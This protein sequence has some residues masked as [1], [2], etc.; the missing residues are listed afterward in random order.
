[1][2]KRKQ[3]GDVSTDTYEPKQ[4]KRRRDLMNDIQDIILK[5]QET[6]RQNA[7]LKRQL[8]CILDLVGNEDHMETSM[9]KPMTSNNDEPIV[10]FD[11]RFIH[12]IERIFEVKRENILLTSRVKRFMDLLD[13]KEG[14][15][16]INENKNNQSQPTGRSHSAPK[17]T[18]NHTASPQ[19]ESP[20][21]DRHV[22]DDRYPSR[23]LS[24]PIIKPARH[25]PIDQES[26]SC[27]QDTTSLFQM[28]KQSSVD[29]LVI[30]SEGVGWRFGVPIYNN[31]YF[32]CA[33]FNDIDADEFANLVV[34]L[35]CRTDLEI[36]RPLRPRPGRAARRTVKRYN[37][38]ECA[39]L[40]AVYDPVYRGL[41]RECFTLGDDA[42]DID[43][44]KYVSD[45]K[46][47]KRG[48]RKYVIYEPCHR[49]KEVMK[50][51]L[52]LLLKIYLKYVTT[53]CVGKYFTPPWDLFAWDGD[54]I[55]LKPVASKFNCVDLTG[56]EGDKEYQE[57]ANDRV[58]SGNVIVKMEAKCMH[59]VNY[60]Y[61]D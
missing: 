48:F 50:K 26:Q 32:K 9:W 61:P 25:K 53:G 22:L 37:E 23:I 47:H 1:M 35:A 6:F 46:L 16:D 40:K 7:L 17:A 20:S 36:V 8:K 60:I 19:P 18:T 43:L 34:L 4:K 44:Q 27:V 14:D 11:N 41:F 21:R 39:F 13:E 24:V 59:M 55:R 31:L 10:R 33:D 38:A 28:N 56:I 2:S 5:S 52:Y 12:D 57:T 54:C 49:I 29:Q 15:D 30:D 58:D 3:S 45:E 42:M 51:R